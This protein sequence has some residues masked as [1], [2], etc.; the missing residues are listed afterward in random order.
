MVIKLDNLSGYSSGWTI[1][2]TG[3]SQREKTK[4]SQYVTV[5]VAQEEGNC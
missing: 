2:G 1:L 4:S 5:Y 3:C